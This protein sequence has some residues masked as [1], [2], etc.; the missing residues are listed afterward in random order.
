[1][2]PVAVVGDNPTARA[3]LLA[4]RLAGFTDL[5]WVKQADATEPLAQTL[6]ANLSRIVHALGRGAELDA[7]AYA[8]DREQVR[9]ANSAYLLS[10]LPLGKF[11]RDRYGANHV[12]IDLAELSKV[13]DPEAVAEADADLAALEKEH[14]LVLIC[15]PQA[16]AAT[17]PTHAL[18]H[19]RLPLNPAMAKANITWLAER[20]TAWQFATRN[21]MHVLV[22]TPIDAELGAEEWHPSLQAAI[23]QATLVKQYD[24]YHSEVR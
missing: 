16:T 15:T 9:F 24:A 1:M 14:A 5:T 22:S 2:Y 4:C 3:A 11:S 23:D 13:L 8:P 7:A 17:P 20:Q 21:A 10:E 18:W 12:N 6:P 19:A